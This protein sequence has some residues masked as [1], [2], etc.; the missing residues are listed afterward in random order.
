M[1]L[2]AAVIALILMSSDC[3]TA[4]TDWAGAIV[5]EPGIDL[6]SVEGMMFTADKWATCPNRKMPTVAISEGRD[7]WTWGVSVACEASNPEKAEGRVKVK[8]GCQS[9]PA[10]EI[11]SDDWGRW[12]LRV[13]CPDLFLTS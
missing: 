8:E 1:K 4:S 2:H 6:V 7:R 12:R 11:E 5:V 3:A 10:L 13:R 9:K